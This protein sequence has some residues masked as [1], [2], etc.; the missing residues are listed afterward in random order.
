MEAL[1]YCDLKAIEEY[2]KEF[3]DLKDIAMVIFDRPEELKSNLGQLQKNRILGIFLWLKETSSDKVTTNRIE[4]EYKKF[5]KQISRSS[6]SN[7]LNQLVKE[8]VLVKEKKGKQVYYKIAHELPDKIEGDP[9]WFVKN[10]CIYPIYICRTS[11]FARKLRIEK[12]EEGA[13]VY[14]LINYNLIR[15]RLKKCSVCPFGIKK[16]YEVVLKLLDNQYMT[17]KNLLP[18]ELINYVENMFGELKIFNG[19]SLFPSWTIVKERIF[20][21]SNKFKREIKDQLK[22]F[23]KEIEMNKENSKTNFNKKGSS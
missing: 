2:A 15:N 3:K 16:E 10:F 21:F 4:T 9:F 13:F 23:E 1:F 7:Y 5:F 14:K 20:E 18:K 19:I 6:I 22:T 11:Y 12:S 17:L 8:N